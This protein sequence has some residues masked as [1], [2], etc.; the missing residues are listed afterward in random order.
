[1]NDREKEAEDARRTLAALSRDGGLL[2]V[3]PQMRGDDASAEDALELWAKRIGRAL[4]FVFLIL[5][6]VNLFTGWFF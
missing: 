3:G 5:L 6:A 4:G 2:G 1:M